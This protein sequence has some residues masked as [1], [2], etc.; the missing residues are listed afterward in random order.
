MR[1]IIYR[2]ATPDASFDEKKKKKRVSAVR[3]N[4][5]AKRFFPSVSEVFRSNKALRYIVGNILELLLARN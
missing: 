2:E 3:H 5:R 4:W 1:H